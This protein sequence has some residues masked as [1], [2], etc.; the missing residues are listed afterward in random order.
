MIENVNIWGIIEEEPVKPSC[1]L[2]I[3]YL[4]YL[5]ECCMFSVQATI[6]INRIKPIDCV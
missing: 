1:R 2:K 6:G 5:A 4:S 3:D